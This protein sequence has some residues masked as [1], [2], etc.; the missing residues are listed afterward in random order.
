M[1]PS[2]LLNHS[3]SSSGAITANQIGPVVQ[4]SNGARQCPYIVGRNNQSVETVYNDIP[5]LP[6]CD[7]C[8]SAC[9]RFISCFGSYF[10]RGGEDMNGTCSIHVFHVLRESKHLYIGRQVIQIG[11]DFVM[12][13]PGQ[14][15]FSVSQ[16]QCFP[17]LHQ[18]VHPFPLNQSTNKN[19]A[20]QRRRC[21]R[22]KPAHVHSFRH[23]PKLC[24]G[25]SKHCKRTRPVLRAAQNQVPH[26]LCL[27]S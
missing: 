11:F 15:E 6:R 17:C 10:Q 8:Q 24:V 20:K 13:M 12:G 1:I 16:F 4:L 7:L 27:H 22:L 5:G 14:P 26:L 23:A 9:R 18:R 3:C 2:E 19:R 25:K 21:P